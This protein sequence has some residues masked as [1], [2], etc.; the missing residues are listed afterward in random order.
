MT[1]DTRKLLFKEQLLSDIWEEIDSLHG[2]ELDAFLQSVGLDV[3]TLARSYTE[4]IRAAITQTKR[5]EFDRARNRVSNQETR[6]PMKIVTLDVGRKRQI[7]AAINER[8]ARTKE[9]TVAARNRKIDAE[10]DLD[11]FLEACVR[12]GLIDEEGNLRD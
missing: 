2:D 8:V 9:M 7:L 3:K 6:S 1:S 4:T 5:A 10:Q 12:L 11:T